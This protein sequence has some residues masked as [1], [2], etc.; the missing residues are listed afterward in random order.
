MTLPDPD[1]SGSLTSPVFYYT[2]NGNGQL[3]TETDPLGHVTTYA[4]DSRGRQ[5]SVTSPDPDG[6]GSLTAPV[7]SSAPMTTTTS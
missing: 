1:G 7:T 6:S 4:Y 2:Y 3:V 5:T